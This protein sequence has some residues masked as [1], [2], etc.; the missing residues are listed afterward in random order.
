MACVPLVLCTMGGSQAS[1]KWARRRSVDSDRGRETI[2]ERHVAEVF[3]TSPP[4][5]QAGVLLLLVHPGRHAEALEHLLLREPEHGTACFEDHRLVLRPELTSHLFQRVCLHRRNGGRARWTERADTLLVQHRDCVFERSDA[6]CEF[7]CRVSDGCARGN[8][9]GR[10]G[11][12]P[13]RARHGLQ[14]ASQPIESIDQ[15]LRRHLETRCRWGWWRVATC[16]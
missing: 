16:R 12:R 1:A 10:H 11:Q 7:G 9:F 13:R 15:L 8:G 5:P 6:R 4:G 3:L 2:D 14:G